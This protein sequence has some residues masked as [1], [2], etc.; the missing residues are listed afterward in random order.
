MSRRWSGGCTHWC[1]I[2]RVTAT[3]GFRTARRAC[4]FNFASRRLD[5]VERD[6]GSFFAQSKP[7]EPRGYLAVAK[8]FTTSAH[9]VATLYLSVC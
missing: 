7:F 3:V 2:I 6:A 5:C 8:A 9:A 1:V 4:G